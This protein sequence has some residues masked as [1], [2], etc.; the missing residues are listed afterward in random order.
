MTLSWVGSPVVAPGT[1]SCEMLC[2]K[3][4]KLEQSAASQ[5]GP[6]DIVGLVPDHHVEGKSQQS[7]LHEFFGFLVRIKVVFALYSSLLSVQWHYI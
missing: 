3:K 6:G 4:H 7:E 1:G 5:A 2:S